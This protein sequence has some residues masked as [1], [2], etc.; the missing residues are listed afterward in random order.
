MRCLCGGAS[1]VFVHV[2]TAKLDYPLYALGNRGWLPYFMLAVVL[3]GS[4]QVT[5]N[6]LG[7][8]IVEDG[9]TDN[10]VNIWTLINLTGLV[11]GF[12]SPYSRYLH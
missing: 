11:A 12:I 4:V 3:D 8:I 7:C 9:D 10:L 6:C 5:G 2:R 1:Y